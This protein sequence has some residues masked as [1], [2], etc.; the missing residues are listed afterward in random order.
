MSCPSSGEPVRWM[1]SRSTARSYCRTSSSNAAVSPCWAWRIS[2]E[3]STR[4][5]APAP[6][7]F[8]GPSTGRFKYGATRILPLSDILI[9]L[10]NKLV[11][12]TMNSQDETRLIRLGFNL[13]PQAHDVRIHGARGGKAVVAP[14]IL[15]QAIAA[16][17]LAGMAQ[18][19]LEQLELLRRKIHRFAAA[20]NLAAFQ[21]YLDLAE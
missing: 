21:I 2:T 17:S 8:T 4:I 12:R 3:S 16:Q 13:L 1:A 11:P 18:K 6:A 5:G 20:R 14:H 19:I 15:E 9:W 10:P 7:G